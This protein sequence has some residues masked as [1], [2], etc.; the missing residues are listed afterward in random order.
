MLRPYRGK[1][2][3]VKKGGTNIQ[4]CAQEIHLLKDVLWDKMSSLEKP[5][6]NNRILARDLTYYRKIYGKLTKQS[7]C[8]NCGEWT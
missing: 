7:R 5:S 3:E 1:M 6:K 2:I 4:L 8:V